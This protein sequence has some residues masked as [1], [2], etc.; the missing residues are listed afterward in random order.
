M[1]SLVEG[2]T[3]IVRCSSSNLLPADCGYGYTV[4]LGAGQALEAPAP[5]LHLGHKA[6]LQH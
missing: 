4:L 6:V 3:V 1:S 5:G 2:E